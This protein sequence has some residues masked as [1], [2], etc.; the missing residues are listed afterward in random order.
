M[1]SLPNL[2]P[3]LPMFNLMKEVW[4]YS[5]DATQRSILFMDTM[6]ERG[7]TYLQ[8]ALAGKPPVL[9][10]AYEVIIDGKDLRDPVN[11]SLLRIL[12]LP[13]YPTNPEMRPIIIIDPRAGHGP[14][15]GG[16]KAD[17]QVG[18]GLRRGHPV[19]FVTF[20]AHP[21]EGQTLEDVGTAEAIFIE[22]V[23]R[24]HP[25]SGEN[26]AVV[27]NCQAGW[28]VA[29]LA[30][31]RPDIMG[32]LLLN[33]APL[34]YWTGIEGKTNI[35]YTGGLLGG[36][37]LATWA[38][39][40][41]NGQ[42]DGANLVQNFENLNPANTLWAKQYNLY[43]NIDTERERYLDFEKWWGGFFFYGEKEYEPIV[44]ELFIGNKLAKGQII[45][46]DGSRID[47]K[48]IRSPIVVFASWGDD[49]TPPPQALHWII[50]AYGHEDAIVSHEQVIVYLLHDEIGHLGI[51]VS[52]AVAR[53]EHNEIFNTIELIDNLPP[54]LYEMIIEKKRPKMSHSNIEPG[55]FTVR[56]ER[57][58][59]QDIREL[60][61]GAFD[62]R[63]FTAVAKISE[64]N[65]KIYKTVVQPFVRPLASESQAKLARALHPLR[66]QRA[67]LSDLNPWLAPLPFMAAVVKHTRK[68]VPKSNYFLALQED[69]SVAIT[70]SLNTYRDVRD[71]IC[72][73]M[74]KS[75]YGTFGLGAFFP[76]VREKTPE[77]MPTFTDLER[78]EM[79]A[80]YEMGGFPQAFVR[81]VLA[82][83]QQDGMIER[84]TAMLAD[85]LWREDARLMDVTP[86]RRK[87]I[88]REQAR[89]LYFDKN[90]AIDALPQLLKKKTE[91]KDA[92][93]M[94]KHVMLVSN[95][96][97]Q[98]EGPV[99]EHMARVLDINL[100]EKLH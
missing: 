18:M 46:S 29:S 40:I 49:I 97:G 88:I 51:F 22:E 82:I 10:F 24:R 91:R 66:V 7:N 45:T 12:P 72:R 74:F 44:S 33:G 16:S 73:Y 62:E 84:R 19:Y 31:L 94:L 80:Q 55:D 8:H 13:D 15:V 50:D 69:M 43:S 59:V 57:R 83:K 3:G 54:G 53:K 56:V 89:L 35:R 27:G 42:F 38:L 41:G 48:N 39:D 81:M 96:S 9:D 71:G 11:Y 20:E 6:R 90:R 1:A 58:R 70:D 75:M 4:D 61:A 28:A 64:L 36:K 37:W 34:S 14:G 65:D 85:Q 30:T 67:L 92:F 68:P 25:E 2:M 76:E 95:E 100:A 79:E 87:H 60:T 52:A 98:L 23:M 86:R 99:V 17:S 21:V 26:P 63:P 77:P 78:E 93:D 5:V 47:L 32:P